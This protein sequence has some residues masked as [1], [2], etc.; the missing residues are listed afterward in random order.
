M[1]LV[2]V[3]AV[4]LLGLLWLTP[5][6]VRGEPPQSTLQL[7]PPQDML[8]GHSHGT[9]EAA[10]ARAIRENLPLVVWAGNGDT[11]CPPCVERLRD[12]AVHFMGGAYP[13]V[14]N[15]LVVQIPE[16]GQLWT[17]STITQ[18]ITGDQTYGHVPSIRRAIR[19]WRERRHVTTSGWS[20]EPATM[21][22][23][24]S[25]LGPPPDLMPARPMFR[26]R[27]G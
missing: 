25:M 6:Q 12:E 14:G 11:I 4:L 16:N 2:V 8:A 21:M 27:G 5:P 20:M 24:G 9:Y 1:R 26:M 15:A 10:A 18:W 23:G 22:Y 3:L 19:A 13:G 7:P 17:V